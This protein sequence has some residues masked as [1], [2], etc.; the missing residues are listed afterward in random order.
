MATPEAPSEDTRHVYKNY[1]FLDTG[2][3]LNDA[4]R[5]K[6]FREVQLNLNNI[7]GFDIPM[8][9]A[10]FVDDNERKLMYNYSVNITRTSNN[11]AEAVVT[12]SMDTHGLVRNTTL[13]ARADDIVHYNAEYV[14]GPDNM[15]V[16]DTTKFEHVSNYKVRIKTSGKGYAPRAQ[17]L[18]KPL[19]YYELYYMNW[20]YRSMRQR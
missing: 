3:R 15:F 12:Q 10:I 6:R 20:V 2:Y 14:T 7:D 13:G 17:L 16:L 11:G 1:Q 8:G 18:F 19:G 5:K 4:S 9:C